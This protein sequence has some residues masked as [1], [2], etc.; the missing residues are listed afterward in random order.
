[1]NALLLLG[2][3]AIASIGAVG[4]VRG[5]RKEATS[6]YYRMPSSWP[7][8]EAAWYGFRRT[9]LISELFAIGLIASVVF[10]DAV[11]VYGTILGVL[12]L[13]ALTIFLFNWPRRAV[14]PALRE[15]PGFLASLRRRST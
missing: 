14:P 7:W 4:L 12:I 6:S 10:P 3:V 11:L 15:Q 9:E 5:W 1:M 8:G 13:L 2:L